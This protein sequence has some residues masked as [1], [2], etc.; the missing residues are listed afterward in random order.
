MECVCGPLLD[1]GE[2]ADEDEAFAR[3]LQAELDR[4]HGDE[5]AAPQN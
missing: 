2:S 1:A 3:R 4:L 5:G